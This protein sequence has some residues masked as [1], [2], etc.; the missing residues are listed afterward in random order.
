MLSK[1][2]M[3]TMVQVKL[4]RRRIALLPESCI[5]KSVTVIALWEDLTIIVLYL[6]T[7]RQKRPEYFLQNKLVSKH[8]HI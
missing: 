6:P 2:E 1:V 5:L 7:L 4:P 3:V 8:Q